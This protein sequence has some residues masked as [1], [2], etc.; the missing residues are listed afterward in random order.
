MDTMLGIDNQGYPRL[1]YYDEDTNS[2]IFN[3]NDILWNFVRD[4][5]PG[6]VADGYSNFESKS[7]MFTTP[8]I[9]PYFNNN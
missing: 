3:G 7:S 9:L 2:E 5:L 8:T 4:A 1:N 6:E